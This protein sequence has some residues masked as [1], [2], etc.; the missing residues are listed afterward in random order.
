[1]F[2]II[3]ITDIEYIHIIRPILFS[4][5]SEFYIFL[6]NEN[7]NN[8]KRKNEYIKFNKKSLKVRDKLLKN[9]NKRHIQCE[10]AIVEDKKQMKEYFENKNVKV[11]YNE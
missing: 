8:N 5:K 11:V 4:S 10:F 9:F 2:D 7:V 6:F 1:M 3:D